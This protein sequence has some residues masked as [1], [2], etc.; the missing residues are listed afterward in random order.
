MSAECGARAKPQALTPSDI[1][2]LKA[3]Y[4]ADLGATTISVQKDSITGGM[5]NNMDSAGG[6]D[7]PEKR[8][9][10]VPATAN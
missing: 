10:V 5:K 7:S 3:L 4:A 8:Q 1:A 6:N 9:P 2:Y